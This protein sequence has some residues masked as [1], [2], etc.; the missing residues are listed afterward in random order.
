MQKMSDVSNQSGNYVVSYKEKYHVGIVN[1]KMNNLSDEIS[2]LDDGRFYRR[3]SL[4]CGKG[5]VV[6]I[7]VFGESK[8]L[9]RLKRNNSYKVSAIIMKKT[10]ANGSVR[11]FYNIDFDL[12]RPSVP[13]SAKLKVV[14][15]VAKKEEGKIIPCP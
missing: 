7:T 9:K 12:V 11:E 2:Q 5:V 1:F 8:Y 3:F 15:Q 10:I 6:N 13:V 14:Q 4:P